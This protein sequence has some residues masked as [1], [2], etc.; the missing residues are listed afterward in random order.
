[1]KISNAF[2][3]SFGASSVKISTGFASSFDASS[4]KI[5]KPPPAPPTSFSSSSSSW[6]IWKGSVILLRSASVSLPFLKKPAGVSCFMLGASLKPVMSLGFVEAL[7][8]AKRVA[9]RL[10]LTS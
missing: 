10:M 7:R 9:R 2:A 5:S 1:M 3:S 8:R 6:K 4:V